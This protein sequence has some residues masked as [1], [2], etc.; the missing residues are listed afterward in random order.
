MTVVTAMKS[1]D[2]DDAKAAQNKI[3]QAKQTEEFKKITLESAE[4][5]GELTED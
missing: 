5:R 2:G 3:D 4:A 1:K